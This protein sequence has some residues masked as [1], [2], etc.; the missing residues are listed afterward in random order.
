MDELEHTAKFCEKCGKSVDI[1]NDFCTNCGSKINNQNNTSKTLPKKLTKD[2][3]KFFEIEF[4]IDGKII[5]VEDKKEIVERIGKIMSDVTI[6]Q[7]FGENYLW[8]GESKD[9][10]FSK[11]KKYY[12]TNYRIGCLFT[13]EK[14]VQIPIKY[15]DVVVMNTHR[16]SSRNGIGG[17]ISLGKGIGIGGIQSSGKS[18]TIGDLNILFK[19]D[20]LITIPQVR[21]P[22]GLKN[23]IT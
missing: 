20:V 22:V 14:L 16:A 18:V 8:Q 4:N 21:D 15:V 7:E 1:Q 6:K 19:G 2:K 5:V 12:L 17:F 11:P 3:D 13:D 23:L 9:G 10:I